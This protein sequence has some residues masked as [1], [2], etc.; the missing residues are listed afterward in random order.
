MER[1]F[2]STVPLLI[3]SCLCVSR[4]LA[5][6]LAA[7]VNVTIKALKANSAVVTWDIPEGD[8]VIG[9]AI[10]QQ[11]KDVR[12]LRFIQEV[13]TTTRS[14]ALWDLEEETDY[15]VHVQSISVSGPMSPHSEPKRFRTP[16]EAETQASK[17]KDE[18]TME[19]VGAQLRAGEFIIIVVVLIMWAGVIAL[20]CRQYDII[21]DN[22]PNNNKDKAKTSSEC[23]TPEHPTGG[24]LRIPQKQ[25]QPDSI[26]EHHRGVTARTPSNPKD[27]LF[28]EHHSRK[29]LHAH[30]LVRIRMGLRA[31]PISCAQ[32][33]GPR[34]GCELG[35]QDSSD[36]VS[37][38]RVYIWWQDCDCS[39]Y[40][41]TVK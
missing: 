40:F 26:C 41:Q 19:E 8:P 35:P 36:H 22:E 39:N 31:R 5:D 25:Q 24:L 18:V 1:F 12:M 3:L 27:R 33:F 28:S 4:V 38:E 34:P 9:F 6:S 23:S 21:K 30:L 13:N 37:E 14:C 7:P 29:I 10:T 32:P 20:F 16:K 11:K 17:S 15:I 2:P